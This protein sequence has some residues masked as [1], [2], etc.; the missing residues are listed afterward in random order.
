MKTIYKYPLQ[1]G[2]NK[3][4]VPY[5]ARVAHFGMQNDQPHVW[6]EIYSEGS[7]W[8]YMF[9]IYGTGQMV[10]DHELHRGTCFDGPF[11][12]HLYEVL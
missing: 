9:N 11:V 10:E 3:L 1:I 2:G 12:W 4:R 5:G 6:L 8:E 7:P